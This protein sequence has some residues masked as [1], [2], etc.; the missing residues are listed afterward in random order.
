MYF[1]PKGIAFMSGKKI[2]DL[3]I[4]SSALTPL[5][6]C[7]DISFEFQTNSEELKVLIQEKKMSLNFWQ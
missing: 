3:L 6:S 5:L 7:T 4:K 1:V 2:K